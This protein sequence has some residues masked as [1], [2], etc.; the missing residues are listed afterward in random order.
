M[1]ARRILDSLKNKSSDTVRFSITLT[2]T[3]NDRVERIADTLNV[4]KQALLSAI[5]QDSLEDIEN[6]MRSDVK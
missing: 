3:Q 5:I 6:E 4:T 1:N 2:L